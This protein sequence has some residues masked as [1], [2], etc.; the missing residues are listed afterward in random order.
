MVNKVEEPIERVHLHLYKRD[1]ERVKLMYG[2]KL[3]FNTAVR[4]LVHQMLD[5][6]EAAARRK[7]RQIPELDLVLDD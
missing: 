3:K 4:E 5:Q 2:G 7:H 6:I 1:I